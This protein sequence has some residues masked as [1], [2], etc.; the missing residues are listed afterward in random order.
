MAKVQDCLCLWG[1]K[2]GHTT[3]TPQ[4][5]PD[6]RGRKWLANRANFTTT[7]NMWTLPG[8]SSHSYLCR[9]NRR[10][11]AARRE[12]I[13]P[14]CLAHHLHPCGSTAVCRR[15]SGNHIEALC[16]SHPDQ[17]PGCIP[18]SLMQSWFTQLCLCNVSDTLVENV[19][20]S[21]SGWIIPLTAWITSSDV[22][23]QSRLSN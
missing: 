1:D 2:C 17:V 9:T 20:D 10:R 3:N 18:G 5:A 7:I 15:C 16:L 4:R 21:L 13:C 23:M 6:P 8:T 22:L 14:R 19:S 12:Q 11:E